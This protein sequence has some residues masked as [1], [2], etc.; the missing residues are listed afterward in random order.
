[1]HENI[2]DA[3]RVKFTNKANGGCI[4]WAKYHGKWQVNPWSTQPLIR[5]L[6]SRI[7]HGVGWKYE[8][9]STKAL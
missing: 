4:I 2:A 6:I 5:H 9:E 7:M 8:T 1:M 3:Y